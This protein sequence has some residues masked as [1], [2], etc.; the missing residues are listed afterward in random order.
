MKL[1]IKCLTF[2]SL[3]LFTFCKGKEY[4]FV[5][6][7]NTNYTINNIKIGCGSEAKQIS[8]NANSTSEEF[9][10]R[11]KKGI[12]VTE[13]ILCAGVTQYSDTNGLH[14]HQTGSTI[15]LSS[16]S[17]KKINALEISKRATTNYPSDVFQVNLQ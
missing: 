7:N 12:G 15:S 11:I 10:L 13:P 16:L 6:I 5:V 14:N 4:K 1:L 3:I 9:I 2:L 17:K 8:V